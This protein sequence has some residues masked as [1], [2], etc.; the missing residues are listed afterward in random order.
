MTTPVQK[1]R[2]G[3]FEVCQAFRVID[4]L[5]ADEVT[6]NSVNLELMDESKQ[7][8]L[9]LNVFPIGTLLHMLTQKSQF[10]SQSLAVSQLISLFES[11]KSFVDSQITGTEDPEQI[12][13][14][15]LPNK[16]G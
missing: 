15:I 3:G 7:L 16:F 9:T 10:E 6:E 13:V 12:L 8:Q 5:M 2:T 4:W 11:A 1:C 14:P